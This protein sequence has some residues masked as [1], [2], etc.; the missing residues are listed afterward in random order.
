[1]ATSEEWGGVKLLVNLGERQDIPSFD[2]ISLEDSVELLVDED[3]A[4]AIG[5]VAEET[6]MVSTSDL[7][8]LTS[9]AE[10]AQHSGLNGLARGGAGEDDGVRGQ[11]ATDFFGIGGFG[12]TFVYVVDCSDSMNDRGKF[13]RA[14]YELLQSIEQ[15]SSEQRYFVIFYSDDAYP[16]EDD[17][18]VPA[19]QDSFAKTSRWVNSVQPIGGT[20]PLPALLYALSLRPDAIYFLSDGQFDPL[21]IQHLRI[22][23]RP[24]R[25]IKSPMIPIH[26]V[27]FM[28]RMTEGLM[29]S[30]ARNSGGEYRF[31]GP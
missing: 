8:D 15:L 22:R 11:A 9:L 3:P 17:E 18:P 23:N 29:R 21:T 24:T 31:V 13:E 27:A 7:A 5:P 25:R 6:P 4:A 19:T 28:D 1:M 30:I 2:E 20:N 26:T 16:M 12:Q 14:R 10:S